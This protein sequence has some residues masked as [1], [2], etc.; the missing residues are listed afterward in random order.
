[1]NDL[2]YIIIFCFIYLL[3]NVLSL[4]ILSINF[5]NKMSFNYSFKRNFSFEIHNLKSDN[6]LKI[7]RILFVFANVIP[8][9]NVIYY[10]LK[11]EFNHTLHVYIIVSGVLILLTV[12]F[13]ILL[14]ITKTLNINL[15]LKEYIFY[16]LSVF[17]EI[18][19]FL[20][21]IAIQLYENFALNKIINLIYLLVLFLMVL[22]LLILLMNK[23]LF[24]WFKLEKNENGEYIR[25]KVFILALYEWILYFINIAFIILF[26]VYIYFVV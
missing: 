4:I 6:T 8:I 23:K 2:I 21:G 25:P 24:E 5:N 7:G 17:S 18:F 22:F 15:F 9:L 14:F 1:M 19:I 3:L 11:L 10:S 20:I 12:I 26:T 16:Y 13:K